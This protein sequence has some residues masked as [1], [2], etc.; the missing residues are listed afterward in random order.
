MNNLSIVLPALEEFVT[1]CNEL[2]KRSAQSVA[3]NCLQV[4]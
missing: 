1:S 4:N 3:G 2:L